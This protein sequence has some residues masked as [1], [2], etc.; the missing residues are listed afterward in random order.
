MLPGTVVFKGDRVKGDQKKGPI[1]GETQRL[2]KGIFF[3]EGQVSD[4]F[5]AQGTDIVYMLRHLPELDEP[6]PV[7]FAA[8]KV[9]V[10]HLGDAVPEGLIHDTGGGFPAVNMGDGNATDLGLPAAQQKASKAVSEQDQDIWPEIR[11]ESAV[12]GQGGP[13]GLADPFLGVVGEINVY[14]SVRFKTVLLDFLEGIS[15]FS[16]E[17]G[18]RSQATCRWRAGLSFNC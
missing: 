16:S 4:I 13:H 14:A 3:H 9:E 7:G 17:G 1:K 18:C 10:G 2:F 8:G 5:N 15:L 6:A 11:E 12:S